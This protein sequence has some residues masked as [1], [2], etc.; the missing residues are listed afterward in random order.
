MDAKF[1]SSCGTPFGAVPQAQAQ[2]QQAP[3][4]QQQGYMP[5]PAASVPQGHPYV[6][7]QPQR[8]LVWPWVLIG[9]VALAGLAIGI[10]GLLKARAQQDD[11]A[12]TRAKAE[13]DAGLT[14]IQAKVD[15]ELTKQ[16][17]PDIKHMP[18]DVR[19][20]LLHVERTEKMRRQMS[21]EQLGVAQKKLAELSV[22]GGMDALKSLLDNGE[23]TE[24]KQPKDEV[25]EDMSYMRED[26]KQLLGFFNSKQ[27][28]TEC[29]GLHSQ[30]DESIG[31]MSSEIMDL[32]DI[33]NTAGENVS[34]TVSKLE[35]MKGRSKVIDASARRANQSVID[36]CRKY[37]VNPWFEISPDFG[38]SGGLMHSLGM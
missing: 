15:T 5:P 38:D 27:P 3:A 34:G 18:A 30:Y 20:Y 8:K 12:L 23:E 19:D 35:S 37:D 9:I 25:K 26:W 22:G 1:C 31:E 11:T 7:M 13:P 17:A 6:P 28:P 4:P 14:R 36:I 32:I 16:K 2:P 29:S 33:V 24:L 21:M 10:N